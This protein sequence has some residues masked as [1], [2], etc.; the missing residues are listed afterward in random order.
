MSHQL[1]AKPNLEHLKKQ[2]KELLHNFQQGDPESIE[3]LRSVATASPKL[4][5]AQYVIARDYGFV[6]WPK[7]KEHVQSLTLSP[8]EQL[9]VAV[10]A[11]DAERVARVLER[12]RELKSQ[13]NEPM[14]NY[15]GLPAVLAAVQRT[16]RKTID[17]LL[18]TGADINAR[19]KSW[20]GGRGALDECSPELA[21]FLIERGAIVD[22]HSAARLGL[23]DNL[24]ELT[25][26]N[27]NL[28]HARGE[29]GQT[30]LHFASTIEIAKFLLDHG[31]EIDARDLLHESTPAQHMVRVIQARHY[32]RDRQDIARYLVSRGCTTDILMAAALGNLD[33]VRRH[34]NAD[35]DCIRMRV[36][37]KYFPKHDPRSEGT[38]Y[39][40][41]LGRNRTPHQVARDFG[42]EEIFQLLMQR[43]PEDVKLAQAFEL[44]DAE[45]FRAALSKRPNWIRTLSDEDRR[46]L[47][48]AA[49]NNNTEAVKLMLEAGWPVDARGEYDMTSLQWASWHGN[50]EMAREILHHHPQLELD[51]AHGITALGSALHGSENGWHRDTGDYA[52]TVEA[53]LAAGAKAPKVTDDLE[54]SEAVKEVLL[55]HEERTTATGG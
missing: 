40:P 42:H 36:S 7:L 11:S 22:A 33:L 39:I 32:P 24:K 1:P 48:D 21:A 25:E 55:Q 34:I 23:F 38:Y 44:G 8:A 35:P 15:G 31:A 16:D 9:S 27:P 12:H 53:L 13:I 26:A 28:V 19:G 20:A 29:G 51:C 5:D 17:V 47:P 4:S 41:A 3:L 10:C 37:E 52:A 18:R 2:A 49:Q 14:V 6:S 50:A 30:P 45:I 54:A 46:H 43:S